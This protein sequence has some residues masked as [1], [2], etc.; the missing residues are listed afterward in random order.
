MLRRASCLAVIL[1]IAVPAVAGAKPRM[2]RVSPVRDLIDR[3]AVTVSGAAIAEVDHGEVVVTA[4]KRT[5]NRLRRKGYLVMRLRTPAPLRQGAARGRKADFPP[6][7]SG[8]HNYSEMS[9]EIAMIATA[10]PR[11]VQPFSLGTSYQGRAI[12]AAKISDNV[13][14]DEAEPEVLF[15]AGQHAREHLTIEMALYILREL[16]SK[17]GTDARITNIVNNRETYIVFNVNP[18][19][20]EYDIATGNYR[21]WRKNRQPNIGT[22][23]V[24]TDLNRNWSYQWGCC[25][26][27]S[28]TPSSDTFRGPAPFSAPETQRLRDFISSRVVGG[29]QQIKA[30]IDFHT[31]SEL[32]LWP[33]GYTTADTATGLTADDQAMLSTLGRQMAATNDYT[34]EQSSD[35]YLTDGAIDD[36]AWGTYKIA[37]YTFE[38]Y[39]RT[40]YPG[41]YP[42]DEVIGRETRRNRE[43]VLMLEEAADCVYRVIGKQAQYCGA[44]RR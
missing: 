31:Y 3:S 5:V 39:P 36:W 18:D 10:F 30:H 9:S 33:Y 21:M 28:G 7:D 23:D 32:V 12:W 41:F 34:P 17:Y 1:L 26:G 24:G 2:Y 8:Y 20:S 40:F 44:L 37:S 6:A 15:T 11:I 22:T 38:M 29:V 16:T 25:G 35:L 42:P 19:G 13:A 14:I 4:S 27:S 43:A